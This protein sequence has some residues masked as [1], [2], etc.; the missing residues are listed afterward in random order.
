MLE[1]ATTGFDPVWEGNRELAFEVTF[2]ETRNHLAAVLELL[3]RIYKGLRKVDSDHF[4]AVP[5]HLVAGASH[6]TTDIETAGDLRCR[7]VL[8]DPNSI[9][10]SFAGPE[11]PRKNLLWSGEVEEEILRKELFSFVNVHNM[12]VGRVRLLTEWVRCRLPRVKPQELCKAVC[13]RR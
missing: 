8:D 12:K 1:G 13:F 11:F 10:K 7:E 5:R 9:I 2:F 4:V 6:G 3:G